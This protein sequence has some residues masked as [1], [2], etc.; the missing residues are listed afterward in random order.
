MKSHPGKTTT[1]YDLPGISKETLPH[2][3]TP[4]NIQKGFEVCG[5]YHFNQNIFGDEDLL[6]GYVTD[7]PMVSS[8]SNSDED[9]HEEIVKHALA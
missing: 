6:P 4:R 2:A 8:E 3:A 9:K 1:I 7:R 5:I